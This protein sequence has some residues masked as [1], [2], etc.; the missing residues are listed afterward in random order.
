M[1]LALCIPSSLAAYARRRRHLRL[2]PPTPRLCVRRCCRQPVRLFLR[3]T[4]TP[5]SPLRRSCGPRVAYRYGRQGS[6]PGAI[7][8]GRY[9]VPKDGVLV[10]AGALSPAAL[11]APA[12]C[13]TRRACGS[14]L[15]ATGSPL[16]TPAA[17]GSNLHVPRRALRAAGAFRKV[18]T[19][20]TGAGGLTPCRPEPL[21]LRSS[22]AAVPVSLRDPPANR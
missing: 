20:R 3:M 11:A 7:L 9:A 10:G 4:P 18:K 14:S 22:S 6:T 17:V 5:G 19:G 15:C 13:A 1:C 12:E 2:T 16:G 21:R 8:L